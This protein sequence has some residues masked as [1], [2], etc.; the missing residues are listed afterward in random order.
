[1]A[2]TTKHISA[3]LPKDDVQWLDRNA[4]RDNRTRNGQL[5]HVVQRYRAIS[6]SGTPVRKRDERE[7]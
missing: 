5:R 3:R 6:D 1:M 2:N 4:A 7:Q